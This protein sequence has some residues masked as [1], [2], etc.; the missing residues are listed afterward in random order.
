M[1]KNVRR[2][3]K[4][5][6]DIMSNPKIDMLGQR[7]GKLK[8]IKYNS[9][10]NGQAYWLCK[11]DC[12]NEIVVRGSHLRTGNV[13]SCGCLRSD[14]N[15]RRATHNK[16][17]SRLYNIYYGMRKRCYTNT[18][19]FY[20]DYGG[21]GIIICDEWLNKHH[22]F[23]SFC[24]WALNNG[25]DDTLTLERLNVDGNYCPENCTWVSRKRQANNRRNSLHISF[26]GKTLTP[27][28]WETECGIPAQIIRKRYR[29]GYD[30]EKIFDDNYWKK[31][32]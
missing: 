12:G 25:Y 28:E 6:C 5:G 17:R 13:K 16:S 24:E 10:R 8:V 19:K 11:C 20:S 22:G 29:N 23:Q 21:R 18:H 32:R 3:T 4:K 1:P 15:K 30:V 9:S 31:R 27:S 7:S 2:R 26:N 14:E